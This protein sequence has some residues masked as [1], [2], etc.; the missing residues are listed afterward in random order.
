MYVG[1]GTSLTINAKKV[2][3]LTK[4]GSPKVD[5]DEIEVT[6]MDSGSW[7]E[8]MM[9]FSDGGEVSLEGYLQGD[10]AGQAELVK[11]VDSH[12]IADAEIIFPGGSAPKWTFSAYI[13]SF[14]TSAE[15]NGAVGF[16]ASLRVS[17]KPTL[18]MSAAG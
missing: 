4:I 13:K 15:H 2:G 7:K 6:N 16:T 10:D 18:S 17:G 3:K 1:K 9:G 14:E 8:Y 5:T 12:E 11:L